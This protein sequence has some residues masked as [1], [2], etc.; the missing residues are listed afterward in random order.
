MPDTFL[1]GFRLDDD[2]MHG[3]NE[4]LDMVRFRGSRRVHVRLLAE[5]GGRR[6]AEPDIGWASLSRLA[7][8]IFA[9]ATARP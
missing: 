1:V 6:R 5:P 4:K 9:G 2:Q 3:P 7:P 8:D